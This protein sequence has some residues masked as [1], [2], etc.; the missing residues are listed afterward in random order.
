MFEYIDIHSH[1]Y[2]PYYE[3][4]LE[5]QIEAMKKAN[6]ATISVGTGLEKS[7][8]ALSVAEKHSNIFACVGFHPSDLK[9]DSIFDTEFAELAKHSKV[10]AIGECGLD[11]FEFHEGNVE[12]IKQVQKKIFEEHI[13]LSLQVGKPLMLHMRPSKGTMDAYFDSLEILEGYAKKH[14]E[15]LCGNAH[16][17]AGDM[18]VL[19]RFLAIGFTVSFTGVLTFTHDYDELVRYAPLNMIMSETD[20]PFVAPVPYRGKRNSPAY[21][22]E[23]VSAIAR[24]RSEDPILVKKTMVENAMRNFKIS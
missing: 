1:L 9:E 21:V 3:T 14:G 6:I 15:K 2:F 13:E 5:E 22:P 8:E 20:S 18:E 12:K 23:V 4:D 24:I 17:F 10:V 16:F 7:K 19:K 11:Y